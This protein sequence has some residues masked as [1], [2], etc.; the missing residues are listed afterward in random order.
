MTAISGDWQGLFHASRC[1]AKVSHDD[2]C[3]QCQSVCGWQLKLLTRFIKGRREDGFRA[4]RAL[5]WPSRHLAMT[6]IVLN[7]NVIIVQVN[8]NT[9]TMHTHA[10]THARIFP[11]H[12]MHHF[13]Q[14]L[15]APTPKARTPTPSPLERKPAAEG[16]PGQNKRK[17]RTPIA[18][19]ELTKKVCVCA[20]S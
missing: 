14:G 20:C 18:E 8:P 16:P 3:P 15:R 11:R 4:S 19:P 2:C 1:S 17:S 13:E 12:A 10:R 6:F 5:T 9:Q 7:I